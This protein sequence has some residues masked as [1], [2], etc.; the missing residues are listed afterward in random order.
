MKKKIINVVLMVSLV[1]F[2]FEFK[3]L[4]VRPSEVLIE[5]QIQGGENLKIVGERILGV[6]LSI[7]IVLA[8][9]I[10]I[11]IGIKYIMGSVDEKAGYKKSMIPYAVGCI[12]LVCAP[13]IAT[14][15][16]KMSEATQSKDIIQ[17]RYHLNNMVADG[18][19]RGTGCKKIETECKCDKNQA[20]FEDCY[21][22]VGCGTILY[23][24]TR[25]KRCDIEY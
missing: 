10:M 7:G 9:I 17:T 4:A 23:D 14:M 19:E 11:V 15:V 12:I 18:I 13:T 21:Y 5:T 2:V 8:V 1:L 24:R 20:V 22:C 6:I 25:C 3:V 16:Y